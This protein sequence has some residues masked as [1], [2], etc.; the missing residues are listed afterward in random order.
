MTLITFADIFVTTGP[1]AV[2]FSVLR[3]FRAARLLR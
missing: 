1:V 3:V 2:V